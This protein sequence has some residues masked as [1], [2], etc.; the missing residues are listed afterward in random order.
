MKAEI[1]TIGD[2]ILIGQIVDTNSA[3][4]AEQLNLNGIEV[5]Q[6]TSVHDD[7][8]HIL[9]A[10]ADAESR[11]DLILI[12][13]GL[14]PTKDDI[15]K[16]ALC[17][18][19]QCGMHRDEKTLQQVIE[20]LSKRNVT[21]NQL[22]KD[23]ALVPDVC[24][25]LQ[26]SNGTA[27]GMWFEKDDTIFVSMPGV[28]FEM[29][30]IMVE[31]VL[32]RLR[33]NGKLKSIYHQ[34]VLVYGI[35]ESM[36]AEQL[37]EWESALPS[38]VKLAYLPNQLM[39][40]LRL[41]AYGNDMEELKALVDQKVRELEQLIPNNIFG[42][43]NDT[44]SGI[45]G[46]LLQKTGSFVA[47]AESCTGGN[48]AHLYTEIPGSSAYF[49]GGV[50]AYSNEVKMAA[51]GVKPE[52]LEAHGAVSRE[53]AL[54]MVQGV[55]KALNTDYGIAT[56]GIAGPDGGSADKP[57]GTVWIAVSGKQETVVERF[58]FHHNRER[59]IQRSSQ[60]AL[61]MLRQLLISE[62]KSELK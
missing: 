30:G 51:L 25:V 20:R 12:T 46:K 54:E 28:P 4:M 26:N 53:T 48:I 42:Y 59:N 22:N 62:M 36:L 13:G 24:T 52:T 11:A 7:H 55:K 31:E 37:D 41:S 56:T 50:V 3:W 43:N 27:P 49:R 21:I 57:V 35:P 47:T 9:R 40:R 16:K 33:K 17:D 19:F 5:Y 38:F 1:I 44:I 15:T 6:V 8:E 60:T 32:P 23:Q 14:G 61:N 45:T 2:E 10:F 29:Q 34:T 58:V 39:I 18:Y